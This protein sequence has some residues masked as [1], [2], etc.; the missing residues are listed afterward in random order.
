M[1]D[2][3]IE[4]CDRDAA[5]ALF[6]VQVGEPHSAHDFN[7]A[8]EI[9]YGR[10]AI[11]TIEAFARHRIAAI[12]ATGVVELRECL[13]LVRNTVGD[14]RKGFAKS[15]EPSSWVEQLQAHI[16]N[17]LNKSNDILCTHCGRSQASAKSVGSETCNPPFVVRPHLFDGKHPSHAN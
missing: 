13:M 8:H 5:A 10:A 9:K 4:Q 3:T 14:L 17:T 12:E 2:L 11:E 6:L 16:D 7:I 1:T 15:V